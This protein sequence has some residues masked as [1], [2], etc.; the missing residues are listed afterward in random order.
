M[1]YR[2]VPFA[3]WLLYAAGVASRGLVT[4]PGPAQS[5][6][7][8][9]RLEVARASAPVP[10]KGLRIGVWFVAAALMVLACVSV[11]AGANHT[12]EKPEFRTDRRFA[13]A[14]VSLTYRGREYVNADDNGREIQSAVSFDDMGECYNPTEA[15][16]KHDRGRGTSSRV[17]GLRRSAGVLEASTR[18]AF[19]L[20]PGED[21]RHREHPHCGRLPNVVRAQNA[22][23]LSDYILHKYVAT[24]FARR[25]NVIEYRVA[26]DVPRPHEH[27]TFEAVTGYLPADFTR[28]L[29]VNLDSGS[30]TATEG[31]GEQRQP[32]I[33]ATPD[34][35]HAMGVY[36]PEL[37]EG[38]LGYG[39]FRFPGVTNKWNCVF[40][41]RRVLPGRYCYRCFIAVGT[42]DEVS[43]AI[44]ALH[45]HFLEGS[46]VLTTSPVCPEPVAA[47]YQTHGTPVRV[48]GP[49]ARPASRK[50]FR[51][52]GGSSHRP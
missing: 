14:I 30:V 28:H 18:M 4:A 6:R 39:R 17:L 19:W 27:A 12:A 16:S 49:E 31:H 29:L 2:P 50:R 46:R 8:E 26:F 10:P 43:G 48:S 41:A 40:R 1:V 7:E 35:L 5:A 37:P 20:R 34:G 36:S 44:R 24:G 51:P 15:G 3:G 32:V 38:G 42:V 21:Y 47:G 11:A 52:P 45:R 23:V 25:R 13:S 22:T 33:I 9:D